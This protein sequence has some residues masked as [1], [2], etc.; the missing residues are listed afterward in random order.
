MPPEREHYGPADARE[1]L[2]RAQSSLALAR[3]APPTVD[4][5]DIAFGGSRGAPVSV[6]FGPES[7]RA[8]R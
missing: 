1:W 7:Y 8:P 2:A 3:A 6:R 5:E 4:P